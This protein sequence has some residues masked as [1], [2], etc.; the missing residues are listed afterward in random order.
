MRKS[1][2]R[3]LNT[4]VYFYEYGTN[5]GPEP[6]DKEKN[7]L[8]RTWAEIYEPSMKDFQILNGVGS[9]QGL[10]IIIRDPR[11]KYIPSNKHF[12]EVIDYR[13]AGLRWNVLEVR[14]DLTTNDF[15]TIVAGLTS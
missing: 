5:T 4:K 11:G 10:S 14:N 7:L 2:T 13:Y 1:S 15:I 9:K 3:R 12:V 6:G 8:Y